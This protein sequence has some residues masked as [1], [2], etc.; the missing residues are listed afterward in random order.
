M[1]E[2]EHVQS[3]KKKYDNDDDNKQI[4]LGNEM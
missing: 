2:I 1:E 3:T 4:M